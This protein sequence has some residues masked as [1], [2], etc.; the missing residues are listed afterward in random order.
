LGVSATLGF[1]GKYGDDGAKVLTKINRK[2]N[3]IL[4]KIDGKWTKFDLLK[5]GQR[6]NKKPN[7]STTTK[8]SDVESGL[9]E[10]LKNW[11]RAAKD[12]MDGGAAGG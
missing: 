10:L 5:K 2:W 9:E 4:A 1:A 7:T 3:Y 11:G 8:P 6:S 12:Y